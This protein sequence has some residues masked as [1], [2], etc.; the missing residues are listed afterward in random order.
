MI[1]KNIKS[2]I[3]H[4]HD[5]EAHWMRATS[6]VPL[7]GE[8]IIYDIEIDADGNTLA[9]P[10]GRTTPYNYERFKIGDGVTNVN[11]LPF[12]NEHAHSEYITES[13]LDSKGYLTE[14]QSL[15]TING[16]SLVGEGDI[17][18]SGGSGGASII[19]CETLPTENYDTNVIY[20]TT[21][22]KIELVQEGAIYENSTVE[23]VDELPEVGEVYLNLTTYAMYIYYCRK[24]S[25]A[26]LY[27]DEAL[28]EEVGQ[29]AG[30][31]DPG[32]NG[33]VGYITSL[34]E[35]VDPSVTYFLFTKPKLY[36][37]TTSGQKIEIL[38]HN[39][40]IYDPYNETFTLVED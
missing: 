11:E 22:E 37:F 3:V 40:F 25:R 20:A 15:K 28:A 10:E 21:V 24:D 26:Y 27:L 7:Q 18:I 14:H 32:E 5:L 23:I 9:L 12:A 31:H 38:T 4:K 1:Q 17:T 6:F 16:E 35:A 30:W 13:E 33:L 34:D 29:T 8:L 2:R 19:E 39:S 36:R